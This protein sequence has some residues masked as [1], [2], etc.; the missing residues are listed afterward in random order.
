MVRGGGSPGGGDSF[1]ANAVSDAQL[2][3]WVAHP[4]VQSLV[5]L[6]SGPWWAPGVLGDLGA[7]VGFVVALGGGGSSA[8]PLVPLVPLVP[9]SARELARFV[10]DFATTCAGTA[11]DWKARVC[12]PLIA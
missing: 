1:G 10:E 11:G 4:A 6:N 5:H 8:P 3:V 7:D 2:A 12:V 9:A